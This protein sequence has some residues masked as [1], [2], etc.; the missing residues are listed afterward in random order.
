MNASL[1]AKMLVEAPASDSTSDI[2]T[3]AYIE[4]YDAPNNDDYAFVAFK[5]TP[6]SNPAD[7]RVR[8][9][10][11]RTAGAVFEQEAMRLNARSN[12]AQG[13]PYFVWG[14]NMTPSA[15]DCRCVEFR[16]HIANGKP[17]SIEMVLVTRN[18]DGSPGESKSAMFAW[19]A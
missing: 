8:I 7:W 15:D 18:A 4:A 6:K 11:H 16:V 2:V 5:E 17:A 3:L 9:K 12:G 13:K 1:P 19:P 10:G 14:F